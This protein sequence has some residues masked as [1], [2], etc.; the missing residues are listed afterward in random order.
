[1]R[2]AEPAPDSEQTVIELR[3]VTKTYRV[4]DQ[5]VHALRPTSLTFA[6]GE[7]AAIV[8]PSGSG[9]STLLNLI[10]MLDQP[11][12]GEYFLRRR[13]VSGLADDD[14]SDLRCLSIGF[15]FQ[16]FNLFPNL[17][18]TENVCMPMRYAGVTRKQMLARAEELLD[19]LQM[20]DRQAHRPTE[21]SGGQCQ[22]VAIAR[23]LAN[24]PPVLLADEPTGNLDEKTGEEVLQIFHELSS[25]GRLVLMVTHNPVYRSMAHRVIEIHDGRATEG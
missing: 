14:V 24:D 11:T 21:L 18:V 3:E 8:G 9:K 2:H 20:C 6:I 25:Q 10:G 13:R 15:V 22:R 7:F 1:M 19:A 17:T 4:G 12:A 23:A 5:E 16:S